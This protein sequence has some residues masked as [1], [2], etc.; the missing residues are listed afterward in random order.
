TIGAWSQAMSRESVPFPPRSW[1]RPD[2]FSSPRAPDTTCRGGAGRGPTISAPPHS[3]TTVDEE[4]SEPGADAHRTG[5]ADLQSGPAGA[6]PAAQLHSPARARPARRGGHSA[7]RLLRAGGS[8]PPAD[9]GRARHRLAV[10]LGAQS[11]HR[12]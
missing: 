8:E 3:S 4:R 9:A 6:A 5:P 12:P 1:L 2:P 7:G 11:Y 10:S